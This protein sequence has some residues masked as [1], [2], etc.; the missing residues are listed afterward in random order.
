MQNGKKKKSDE[1]QRERVSRKGG[2]K[3]EEKER[4]DV[5]DADF[6]V[7]SV[8]EDRVTPYIEKKTTI[9]QDKK[10]NRLVLL[11]LLLALL[12]FIS[13]FGACIHLLRD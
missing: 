2:T 5:I 9:V 1:R 4:P 7:T 3:M 12:A 11:A 13:L 10:G 8:K 6:K